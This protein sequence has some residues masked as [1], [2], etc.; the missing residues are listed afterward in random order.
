MAVKILMLAFFVD[1]YL[2]TSVLVEHA[3]LK[4][5]DGS[6]FILQSVAVYL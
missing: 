2:D 6:S 5:E 4:A 1:L 3:V